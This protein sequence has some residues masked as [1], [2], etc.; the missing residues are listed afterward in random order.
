M[1]HIALLFSITQIV[2]SAWICIRE[3]YI[4]YYNPIPKFDDT[5]INIEEITFIKTRS[6]KHIAV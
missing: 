1:S 5:E 6:I 3:I 2:M 4:S